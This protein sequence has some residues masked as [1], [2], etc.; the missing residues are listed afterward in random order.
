VGE[1]NAEQSHH[2]TFSSTFLNSDS[3]AITTALI[4]RPARYVVRVQENVDLRE[5][6]VVR[7]TTLEI[8]APDTAFLVPI[9]MIKR[10]HLIDTLRIEDTKG[11]VPVTLGERGT[12]AVMRKVLLATAAAANITT[13]PSAVV[14][15]ICER[16]PVLD[17]DKGLQVVSSFRSALLVAAGDDG[18]TPEQYEFIV[19]LQRFCNFRPLFVPVEA[20]AGPMVK[21][22][23]ERDLSRNEVRWIGLR[24]NVRF[25]FGRLPDELQFELAW[26]TR[27]QSYHF[28]LHAPEMH[29][30]AAATCNRRI[31][32]T[33]GQQ[34]RIRNWEIEEFDPGPAGLRGAHPT[35]TGVCHVQLVG[36]GLN[37]KARDGL[38]LRLRVAEQPL[39]QV[40]GAVARLTVTLLAILAVW[41]YADK[42]V[43]VPG[44]TL[45]SLILALPGLIGASFFV[46]RPPGGF[47]GPLTARAGSALGAIIAIGL[48]LVLAGW[49]TAAS[50]Q[51]ISDPGTKLIAFPAPHWADVTLEVMAGVTAVALGVTLVLL[52]RNSLSFFAAESQYRKSERTTL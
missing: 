23:F 40:G 33:L 35:S 1:E 19:A 2:A 20:A 38:I 17:R 32:S 46:N 52:V 50:R 49:T 51:R 29:Y 22:S 44:P 37:P 21:V 7:T 36:A 4:F 5:D 16:I 3:L 31:G 12:T 24:E 47:R 9:V 42:V 8:E 14:E 26:A 43:A 28:Q 27:S 25:T 34:V 39:G 15:D 41:H 10:D 6:H 45:S 11:V 13:V 18:L 30:V 48:S